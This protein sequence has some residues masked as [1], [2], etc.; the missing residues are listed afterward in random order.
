MSSH[1]KIINFTPWIQ[2]QAPC[3]TS[4]YFA[5]GPTKTLSL[6]QILIYTRAIEVWSAGSSPLG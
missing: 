4:Q 3:I 5:T 2:T 1:E 6:L